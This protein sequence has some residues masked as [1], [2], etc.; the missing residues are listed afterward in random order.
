MFKGIVSRTFDMSLIFS[1]FFT[2][3][4]YTFK[5]IS[6][7]SCRIFDYK[8]CSV[9]FLLCHKGFNYSCYCID[10][11]LLFH[12]NVYIYVKKICAILNFKTIYCILLKFIRKILPVCKFWRPVQIVHAVSMTPHAP[13]I[14]TFPRCS[15]FYFIL[16]A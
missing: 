4:K 1:T 6:S 10:G 15:K 16:P 9:D 5:K 12:C 13:C 8:L 2:L 7:F 11:R 3:K 14:F